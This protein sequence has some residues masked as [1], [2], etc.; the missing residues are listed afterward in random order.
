MRR[1][2]ARRATSLEALMSMRARAFVVASMMSLSITGLAHADE[3]ET[4]YRMCLSHKK[5]GKAEDAERECRIAIDKRSDHASAYY[6]LA[7][8]ER[9]KNRLEDALGHFRKVR[10]LEPT[11]ALGWA[12]EGSVLL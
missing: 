3:A 2:P 5:A 1:A 6:T 12:G 11:N 7:S 10:E 9:A 4:H 8:L